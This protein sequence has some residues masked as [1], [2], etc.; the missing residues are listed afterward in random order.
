MSAFLFAAAAAVLAV[1]AAWAWYRWKYSSI[2]KPIPAPGKAA[3]RI[4]TY[5]VLA[6]GP[7]YALSRWRPSACQFAERLYVL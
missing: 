2:H 4:M 1:P 5:N 7:R 6:D 3:L